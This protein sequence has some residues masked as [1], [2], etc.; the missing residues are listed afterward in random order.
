[1]RWIH[2]DR[3]GQRFRG[4]LAAWTSAGS[5]R[6]T[7][8]R[9][10]QGPAEESLVRLCPLREFCRERETSFTRQTGPGREADPADAGRLA[11]W[12]LGDYADGG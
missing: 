5:P 3:R 7:S 2:T 4:G 9:W 11:I 12:W 6:L 1:M 10:H 8:W